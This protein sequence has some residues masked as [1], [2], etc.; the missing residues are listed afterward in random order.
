M[1]QITQIATYAGDLYHVVSEPGDGTRYDFVVLRQYDDFTFM[2]CKSTFRYPQRINFYDIP[3]SVLTS[4][5]A[6]IAKKEQCNPHTVVECCKV[7]KIIHK[8]TPDY[9]DE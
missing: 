8:G 2:P 7:A 3:D 1:R 6:E 4:D 9:S 5:F